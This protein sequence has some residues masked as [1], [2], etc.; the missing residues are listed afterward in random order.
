M[1]DL[2][3]IF[4]AGFSSQQELPPSEFDL[5]P[6][7]WYPAMIEKSEVK[8]TKKGDGHYINEQF[9]ILDGTAKG[10]KVFKNFNIQNPS[11][12]AVN[13]GLRELQ[14]LNKAIG[15]DIFKDTNQHLNQCCLI[16]VVVK[17]DQNDIRGY[18]PL[19]NQ[20]NT[21]PQ[22]LQSTATY[23]PGPPNYQTKSSE[24]APATAE[25]QSAGTPPWMRK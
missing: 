6:P 20:V 9:G 17:E 7:G 10:K 18:K 16:K 3:N 25:P 4:G 14:D 19:G 8:V 24:P 12:K 1:S 22:S 5:I 15:I 21:I 13:I 11:D 2:S 23:P